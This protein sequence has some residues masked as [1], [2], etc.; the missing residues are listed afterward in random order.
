MPYWIAAPGKTADCAGWATVKEVNGEVAV[1]SCHDLKQDAIAQAVAISLSEGNPELF[2]GEWDKDLIDSEPESRDAGD[3]DLLNERQQEQAESIAEL[4]TKFGMFDQGSGANGAHYAP[5]EAN[6]FKAEGL[7]CRN[8]I[9]FDEL[10]NQCQVVSGAIEPE[11][12]CKLWVIPENE[13]G[14]EPESEPMNRFVDVAE[15][16]VEKLFKETRASKREIRTQ[17]INF[18]SRALDETGMRFSGYAAVFNQPSQDLGGFIEY[19]KPGAFARTL[20]SRNRMMLLWNHDTSAPL[21][22]TRNGSLTLREDARGLFVEATLPNTQLG[23]D[24]AELVRTGTIDAMSFGFKVNRDSWNTAGDQRTLEDVSLFEISLVSYPAYESTSGTVAV[25]NYVA[26][27]DKTAVDVNVLADAMNNFEAGNELDADQ[28]SAI[29]VVLEKLAP[30]S[31][32]TEPAP[33]AEMLA[34]K[35][36]KFNLLLKDLNLD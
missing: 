5:A 7:M 14:V 11:A 26:V 12:V 19:V 6:P 31:P 33:N 16:I 23:R 15:T 10:N 36:A 2:M 25:R 13:I 17:E 35:K 3:W 30:E 20:Q 8:C 1:V 29:R 4:A 32:V 34:L 28:A 18:E 21:A 9:F 22:S 27:A 24:I